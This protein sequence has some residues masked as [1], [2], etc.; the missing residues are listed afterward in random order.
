[1]ASSEGLLAGSLITDDMNWGDL[2]REE[3]AI[4]AS[5][6]K[7]RELDMLAAESRDGI[8]LMFKQVCALR[9]ACRPFHRKVVLFCWRFSGRAL[10]VRFSVSPLQLTSLSGEPE[11]SRSGFDDAA[12]GFK[13]KKR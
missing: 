9:M 7:Q 8:N 5:R 10:L 3:A 13:R 12:T 11:N 4:D 2:A 6:A 1:M